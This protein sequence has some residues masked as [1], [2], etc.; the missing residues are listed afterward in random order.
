MTT[1]LKKACARKLES[2]KPNITGQDKLEAVLKTGISRPTIDKYLSGDV[3]KID[4]ADK[5][6]KFFSR[7]VNQRIES[8]RKSNVA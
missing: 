2:L 8:L 7:K 6:I 1:D 5:L 3:T 4:I